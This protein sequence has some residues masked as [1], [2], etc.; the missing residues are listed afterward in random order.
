MALPGRLWWLRGQE[1]LV[2]FSAGTQSALLLDASRGGIH[3][4]YEMSTFSKPGK[5]RYPS[6]ATVLHNAFNGVFWAESLSRTTNALRDCIRGLGLRV[7]MVVE[8]EALMSQPEFDRFASTYSQVHKQ[9]IAITGEEPEYFAIYKMRDFASLARA[10]DAPHDGTYLDFGSGIGASVAPFKACLPQARLLCADV[11]AD[12]LTESMLAHGSS[13]EYVLLRNTQLPLPES[14]VDGAFACCVFH[15]IPPA[16]H[17]ATLAELRRV[18]KPGAPLMIYEHNPYNP[19][20]VRAVNTCPLD[21]NAVLITAR[22]MRRRCERAGYTSVETDYRVY[23][24]AALK[25]LRPLEDHLRW[26]PLGA[27][28]FVCA[29]A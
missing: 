5:P 6:D 1:D 14:S 24:P 10:F 9:N 19:L 21:K 2:S 3:R 28:Y 16:E 7:V 15:H 13:A 8:K 25:A 23:F 20:T 12:S 26:L 27:Q 4:I 18:L 29:R 11:S 22:E 17:M